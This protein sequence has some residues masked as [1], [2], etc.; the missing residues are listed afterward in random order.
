[1]GNLH[2]VFKGLEKVGA[3]V[4]IVTEPKQIEAADKIV[5]P[6]VGAFKDAIDTLHEKQL[7]EPV[8]K[9]IADG[10]WF[11]GICLGLQMLFDVSYEGGEFEGLGIIPGKV[12]RFDFTGQP[13]ENELKIPHMGW[14]AL[15]IRPDVPLYRGIEDGSF[16]Y[17][18]HSY[19]ID[20][21]DD[22]VIA[23]TT[24]HGGK[25]ASSIHRDNIIATQFHPEK[26]QKVGLQMLKNFTEL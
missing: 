3:Q 16:V 26:S 21:T 8:K 7:V 22:S 12:K 11:L 18:V 14:N 2:S 1:M 5:L 15:N 24:N 19:Y 25:F 4:K 6:G 13:D 20:P 23:T 10:K 9:A 17:F